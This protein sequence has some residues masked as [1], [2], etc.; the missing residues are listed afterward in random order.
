MT[1]H[2]D[3][4][5]ESYYEHRDAVNASHAARDRADLRRGF[6]EFMT[7]LI[8]AFKSENYLPEDYFRDMI[9]TYLD[10]GKPLDGIQASVLVLQ[11]ST[12]ACIKQQHDEP[13]DQLL[14][15]LEAAYRGFGHLRNDID[16]LIQKI[17]YETFAA[18]RHAIE[19]QLTEQIKYIEEQQALMLELS[20]PVIQI[21]EGVLTLPLIGTIDSRR[22]DQV[23]ENILQSIVDHKAQIVILDITGVPLV[24]TEVANHMIKT[25]E[26]VRLLGAE[27]IIVGISPQIA[28]TIVQIGIDLTGVITRSTLQRGLL[29]A[30]EHLGFKVV[31]VETT[32]VEGTNTPES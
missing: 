12:L 19:T 27:C 17:Q 7:D 9:E 32:T 8:A 6:D 21:W 22:A 14:L 24:D 15:K 30:F 18:E 31:D 1:T 5:F 29:E 28:Q 25:V 2:L 20:T 23:M 26:A 10:L 13:V 16:V 4:I 11:D 3:A